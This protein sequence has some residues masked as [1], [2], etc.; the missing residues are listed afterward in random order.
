ML[1]EYF[2]KAMIMHLILLVQP[3]ILC[4]YMLAPY[5]VVSL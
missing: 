1:Y 3:F 4:I 2:L 5:S